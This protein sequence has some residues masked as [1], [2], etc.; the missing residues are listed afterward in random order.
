MDKVEL[1]PW[2]RSRRGPHGKSWVG[3]SVFHQVRS[4]VRP[5]K[6]PSN[7]LRRTLRVES[8]TVP[9]SRQAPLRDFIQIAVKVSPKRPFQKSAPGI[10]MCGKKPDFLI[11]L[12]MSC[13]C[14]P[15]QGHCRLEELSR[16]SIEEPVLGERLYGRHRSRV[17]I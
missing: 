2:F 12:A 1:T 15:R 11:K 13:I 16:L 14:S 7:R 17:L 10:R 5:F 4:A 3:E 8:L 6:T 9:G